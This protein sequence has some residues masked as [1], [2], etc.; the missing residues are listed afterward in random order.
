MKLYSS[1]T[2]TTKVEDKLVIKGPKGWRTLNCRVEQCYGLCMSV[3][4]SSTPQ[5]KNKDLIFA[6]YEWISDEFDIANQ[7]SQIG[8]LRNMIKKFQMINLSYL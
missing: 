7:V 2:F 6:R 5:I 1:L 4:Y 3:R 8:L